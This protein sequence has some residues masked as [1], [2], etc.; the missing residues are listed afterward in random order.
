MSS[1]F[2]GAMQKKQQKV[3]A[4]ESHYQ[5]IKKLLSIHIVLKTLN[6]Q[7]S[8]QT[9]IKYWFT[10]KWMGLVIRLQIERQ[11]RAQI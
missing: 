8:T 6:N 11:I 10:T 1:H 2:R 3:V 9:I 7:P 5:L 4:G